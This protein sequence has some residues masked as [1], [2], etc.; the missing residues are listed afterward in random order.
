MPSVLISTGLLDV[1]TIFI[2]YPL[3]GDWRKLHCSPDIIIR[4][5]KSRNVRWVGQVVLMGKMKNTYRIVIAK[6]EGKIPLGR[7]RRG[8]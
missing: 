7:P 1:L 6:S 2:E 5:I 8:W 3:T 4:V